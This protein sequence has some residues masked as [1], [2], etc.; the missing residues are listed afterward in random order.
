[1][2]DTLVAVGNATAD[3]TVILAKNSDREANEAQALTYVRRAKHRPGATVRCTYV[4]IRRCRKRTRSCYLAL[5]GCGAA[6]WVPT[7]GESPLATRPSLPVSLMA[8]SLDSSAWIF[9][10]LPWSGQTRPERPWS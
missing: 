10:A 6:R 8:S 2:C 1:M 9:S 4:E 3:G 7:S 5:F